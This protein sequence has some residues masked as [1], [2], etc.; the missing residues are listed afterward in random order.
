LTSALPGSFL[1][2]VHA[3]KVKR[4]AERI[5][6]T[7]IV[8]ICSKVSYPTL[9]ID[10]YWISLSQEWTNYPKGDLPPRMEVFPNRWASVPDATILMCN[11]CGSSRVIIRYGIQADDRIQSSQKNSSTNHWVRPRALSSRTRVYALIYLI[12]YRNNIRLL[13]QE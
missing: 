1:P 13:E 8:N 9:R 11:F 6:T 5:S 4:K 12:R 2:A 10:L 3:H 7:R